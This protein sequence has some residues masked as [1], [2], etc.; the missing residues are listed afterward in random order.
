MKQTGGKKNIRSLIGFELFTKI[1]CLSFCFAGFRFM[2]DLCMKASGYSYVTKENLFSFMVSPLTLFCMLAVLAAASVFMMFEMNAVSL[3]VWKNHNQR[4]V[5]VAELFF[6]GIRRT[7]ALFRNKVS[8]MLLAL[9]SL[10]F[11]VLANLPV[12][13][14]FF[15]GIKQTESI[16]M[17]AVKPA[18]IVMLSVFALLLWWVALLGCTVILLAG[19]ETGDVRSLVKTGRRG[20]KNCYGKIIKGLFL[21]SLLLFLLE[22]FF[23]FVGLV[24]F[25]AVLLL[26]TASDVSGIW[27]LRVFERY[28][29]I[30]CV[31]FASVN[32]VIYEY[33]CGTL[34]LVYRK[35]EE[36]VS[37]VAA[38]PPKDGRTN[39]KK[40]RKTVGLYLAMLAVFCLVS[41]ETVFFFRSG[42]ILFAETLDTLCITAHRGASDAAPENTLAAVS[43]AVEE[44]ADYVEIDVRMTADGVPVLLH[45]QALFRTTRVLDDIENVTYAEVS[46]YDAGSSFSEA[47]AG[48]K[49]PSLE[50]VLERFGG[51]IGFNI[52]LKSRGD[53][54]LAKQV[55]ELVERYHLEESCVI[56]SASYEQLMWA[57]EENS[58][59]K[60]GYILSFVYGNFYESEA[61]DFFSLRSDFVSES[62]VEKIHSVGKEIHVWTVNKESELLRMKTIGVDNI[63]TDKPAFAREVVFDSELAE[64]LDGWISLLLSK[65]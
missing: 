35:K 15:F 29:M 56:T 59:L 44:G 7:K 8:G 20:L 45:D 53:R 40:D 1:A 2:M 6:G 18:G 57:K 9:L 28:H 65:K 24:L 54:E 12:V 52:E 14:F 16:A 31:L 32:A 42:N 27:L 55:V 43:L 48:E 62:L 61:A 17:V 11:V 22:F 25:V 23:Y 34:F 21:R 26:V 47:F 51:E 3:A 13:V 39:K 36:V 50:E 4:D 60:T 38:K 19:I 58:E 41:V 46:E 5:T 63:I 49:V 37:R 30:V 10:L 33:F 64:T